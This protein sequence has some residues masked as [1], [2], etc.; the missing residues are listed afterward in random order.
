MRITLSTSLDHVDPGT[1][2]CVLQDQ[3]HNLDIVAERFGAEDVRCNLFG[4]RVGVVHDDQRP[5]V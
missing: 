2:L 3:R 4:C 1:A 5:T